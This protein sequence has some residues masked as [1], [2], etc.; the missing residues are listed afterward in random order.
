MNIF[1]LLILC[2]FSVSSFADETMG[3]LDFNEVSIKFGGW[4]NHIESTEINSFDYKESHNGYGIEANFN[5]YG[6]NKNLLTTGVWSMTDSHGYT[7]NTI[8]AGYSYRFDI[9]KYDYFKN[10]DVN[11][12]LTYSRRSIRVVKNRETIGFKMKKIVLVSPYITLHATKNFHMDFIYIP[13]FNNE[14]SPPTFFL[15]AG[16]KFDKGFIKELFSR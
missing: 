5:L 16:I 7:Q 8:G 6:S 12:L 15:R 3:F 1:Y 10:I 4:S 13:S 14:V 9:W 11:L 2:L